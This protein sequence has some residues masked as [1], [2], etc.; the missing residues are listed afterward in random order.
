MHGTS[1]VPERSP[2]ATLGHTHPVST[3]LND[4]VPELQSTLATLATLHFRHEIERNCLED[5][6]GSREV[7][8]SLLAE[9]NQQYQSTRTA[10]LQRLARLQAQ[11][12]G[13][14]SPY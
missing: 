7:K 6:P 4:L 14:C 12:R 5:W 11:V 2:P 1:A 10:H 8:Q 13:K 9:R 3:D